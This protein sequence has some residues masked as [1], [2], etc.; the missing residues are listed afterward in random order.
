MKFKKKKKKF[1]NDSL[2]SVSMK[3]LEQEFELKN[4]IKIA[5]V[6]RLIGI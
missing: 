3:H 1:F 5:D 2:E 4:K 6:S